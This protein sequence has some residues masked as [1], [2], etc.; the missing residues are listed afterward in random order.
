[1]RNAQKEPS[2]TSIIASLR[3][4]ACRAHRAT[5]ARAKAR[6]R[7]TDC[8]EQGTIVR[9]G[10]RRRRRETWTVFWDMESV[11]LDII[12]SQEQAGLSRAHL[13]RSELTRAEPRSPLAPLA[14]PDTTASAR[15]AMPSMVRATRA[16]SAP[17]ARSRRGQWLATVSR[18]NT[19]SRRKCHTRM[20][21]RLSRRVHQ[22][23]PL[24]RLVRT[25]AVTTPPVVL[26]VLR[27][28]TAP[29][30]PVITLRTGAHSA[31]GALRGR[32]L[33][34]LDRALQALSRQ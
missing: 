20:G 17:P 10:P 29:M 22:R 31:I 14:Q 30:E 28:T 4:S 19:A 26:N 32:S 34:R 11:R 23:R 8:A 3:R 13:A 18:V 27:A 24:A 2:T 12:A 7:S 1:V 15:A 16:S 9:L 5:T 21:R 25:P 6:A 33:R